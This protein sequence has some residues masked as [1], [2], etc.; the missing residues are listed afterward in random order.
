LAADG[1]S[2]LCIHKKTSTSVS[3]RQSVQAALEIFSRVSRNGRVVSI[4]KFTDPV[5]GG[6]GYGFQSAQVKEAAIQ[7]VGI[8]NAS[9]GGKTV[10]TGQCD[11]KV[12]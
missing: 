3:S 10:T 7:T 8:W 11:S 9:I 1:K 2:L 4:L 6:L 12:P 5:L